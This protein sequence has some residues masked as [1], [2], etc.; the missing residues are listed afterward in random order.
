MIYGCDVGQ[1]EIGMDFIEALKQGN[2]KAAGRLEAL[3]EHARKVDV[4]RGNLKL[5]DHQQVIFV[6]DV[7]A[8]LVDKIRPVPHKS[9]IGPQEPGSPDFLSIMYN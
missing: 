3:A 4:L 6:Q 5:K 8:H 7:Q 1:G 2:L 9:W